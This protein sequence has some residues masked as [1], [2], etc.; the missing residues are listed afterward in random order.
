MLD[1][2]GLGETILDAEGGSGHLQDRKKCALHLLEHICPV[3]IILLHFYFI[4]SKLGK[5]LCKITDC[6]QTW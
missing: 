4:Y 6:S 3:P 5:H 2:L 1:K